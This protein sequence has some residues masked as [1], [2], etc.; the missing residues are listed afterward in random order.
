MARTADRILNNLSKEWDEL[1]AWPASVMR[2]DRSEL[3]S[4]DVSST[5]E[6]ASTVSPATVQ[7]YS[8][9]SAPDVEQY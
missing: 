8:T 3:W 4:R 1:K 7:L 2:T 6:T 5:I 9:G